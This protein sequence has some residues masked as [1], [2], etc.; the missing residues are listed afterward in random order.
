MA[1][2]RLSKRDVRLHPEPKDQWTSD[3]IAMMI[4][5]D[6]ERF[7]RYYGDTLTPEQARAVLLEERFREKARDI[8]LEAFK[9]GKLKQ[10]NCYICDAVR[11]E[12][13]HED[14]SKPLDV[15]WLCKRCHTAVHT[16]YRRGGHSLAMRHQVQRIVDALSEEVA[17]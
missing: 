3:V 13:H 16:M 1:K 5:L 11:T 6:E 15:M 2:V 4:R 8:A 10:E 7:A 12:M 17:K 9:T 14:Y